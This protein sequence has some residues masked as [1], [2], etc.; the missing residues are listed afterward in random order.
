MDQ[1]RLCTR[2]YGFALY[3]KRFDDH[4]NSRLLILDFMMKGGKISEFTD[5]GE[6]RRR[7]LPRITSNMAVASACRSSHAIHF[8][9]TE[10]RGCYAVACPSRRRA[11]L[12][13]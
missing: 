4:T 11:G 1:G 3:A 2:E 9:R 6:E 8:L 5:S 10:L 13:R 7:N 12:L